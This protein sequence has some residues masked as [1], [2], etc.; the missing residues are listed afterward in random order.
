MGGSTLDIHVHFGAPEDSQSGCFW[1]EEFTK[2]PA[3]YAMLL[4]TG[5]LF[6]KVNANYIKQ[7]MVQTLNESE[8]VDKAVF[9]ELDKVYDR[10]GNPHPE[11]TH[12]YVPNTYIAQLASSNGN[13]LFGAS[14]HPNRPDWRDELDYCLQQKAVLCKW[15]PSSQMLNPADPAFIPFYRRLASRK[16]PLLCHCGPEYA[17]PT[18][19]E[20]YNEYNNPKYLRIAL[21]QGVTVIIPHCATPYFGF[22]DVDYQDDFEEFLKLFREADTN[23]WNLYADL[24]ALCIPTRSPYIER[25]QDEIDSGRLIY[26]SDYPFPISAF[27]YGRP[28]NIFSRAL[29]LLRLMFMKNL[30]D[31][32]YLIIKEMGFDDCIFANAKALFDKIQY[33]P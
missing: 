3:Y 17:I 26:G 12:L 15:I 5:S 19:D 14:V 16:L 4:I 21:E 29:S 27:S 24:S 6:K 32:N 9:L 22:L 23:G 28:T 25:I 11:K 2:T 10:S 20:T 1:S 7:R 13:V 33:A 8:F 30:L 18:S 31:K